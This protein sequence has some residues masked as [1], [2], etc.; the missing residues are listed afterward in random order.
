M[1]HVD[2]KISGGGTVY[3][4][5]TLTPEAHDWVAE[6]LPAD[7]LGLGDAVAIKWR[8]IGSVVGGAIADGLGVR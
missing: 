3:L 2:F 7:A 5:H 4:L 8:H 1:A 6:H